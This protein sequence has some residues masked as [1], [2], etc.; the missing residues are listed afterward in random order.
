SAKPAYY[1]M[2]MAW[3]DPDSPVAFARTLCEGGMTHGDVA[4]V[5]A[6][7]SIP[8]F[9]R[10]ASSGVPFPRD[11]Y[12][13][14]LAE[15][16]HERRASAGPMTSVLMTEELDA[17]ARANRIKTLR[18]HAVIA[19][20]VAD[21]EDGRQVVGALAV[22]RRDANDPS[23]ALVLFNCRNVVLATG[24]ASALFADTVHTAG[25]PSSLGLGIV[26]GAKAGNLTETR[27]GLTFAK[28]R[29]RLM[30][31]L[32]R[33]IP[34]YYSVGR[35]GR[36]EKAFLAEYFDATKQI[37]SAIFHKGNRW[38]FSTAQLQSLGPSIIDIAV[39]N[40]LAAGRRVYVDFSQNA[41]APDLGKFN[42][43]QLDD[44]ARH[45]LESTG[46][47]QLSPLE[48]LRHLDAA[49]I[50][51]LLDQK[52][53]LREPQ[54]VAISAEDTFGGLTVDMWW[55]TSIPRLF[56]V[57]DVACTHGNPPEGAELNAAQVGGLRAA[58]RIVRDDDQAPPPVDTFLETVRARVES[59]ITNLQRYVYGPIEV[60]SVRNHEKE[61]QER[62]SEAG[63]MIRGAEG[64]AEAIADARRQYESLKTDGQRLS[65]QSQFVDALGNELLCVTEIAFL[66]AMKAYIERGGGSRGAYLV[67]DEHGDATVLTRRGAEMRHRNENMGMRGEILEVRHTGGLDFETTVTPV[68]PIPEA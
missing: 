33:V 4:Y 54:Q 17:R 20:L 53:D 45:F 58:E 18:R 40:E 35:G 15:G 49:M 63:G 62:M 28:S 1:R 65:R 32:Q 44:E 34:H 9:L 47:T 29:V 50:G 7:N 26:A 24:G 60:P 48:R 6:V 64:L 56:A 46:A 55:E 67:L 43:T 31:D 61:I 27:Y 59:E 5:E 66:E 30:G 57:G 19:L 42:I 3:D 14:F 21:E 23:T 11:E 12:G 25:S 2:G 39:Y 51:R 52:A 13:V 41:Q 68:R 10:L 36:D 22:N 8:A 38:A 16:E 37:A